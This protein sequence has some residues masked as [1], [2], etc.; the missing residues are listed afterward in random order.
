MAQVISPDRSNSSSFRALL[1]AVE[2][3]YL[4]QK[5]SQ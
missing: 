5:F 2:R 1:K 4:D 3:L